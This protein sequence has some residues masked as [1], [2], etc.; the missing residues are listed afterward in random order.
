[1]DRG[2]GWALAAALNV[3]LFNA[4]PKKTK[5]VRNAENQRK[6]NFQL[7]LE[8]LHNIYPGDTR[9]KNKKYLWNYPDLKQF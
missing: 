8:T 5:F 9:K 3:K 4:F 7:E 6:Y 1:M 2:G